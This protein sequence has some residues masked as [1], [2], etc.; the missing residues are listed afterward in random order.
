M[1]VLVTGA[2]GFIG[3]NLCEALQNV[4]DDEGRHDAYRDLLPL[5]IFECH[6]GTPKEDLSLFCEQAD[7]VFDLAGVTR[8]RDSADH[9]RVNCGFLSDTLSLLEN[10]GNRCPVMLAS[11]VW[12]TLLGRYEGSEY[13]MSKLAAER[14]LFEYAKRTGARAL[15]YRF[16]NV[17]GKWCRP[18]YSS[19]VATFCDAIANDRPYEVFDPAA[20][21]ELLYI[22]DLVDEMFFAMLG[23]EHRCNYK[24]LIPVPDS[25]GRYCY[26]PVTDHVALGEIVE[27]LNSFKSNHGNLSA[28]DGRESSFSKKLRITFESYY[29]KGSLACP[30]AL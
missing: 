17:Y 16:P 1:R 2:G 6:S 24:G 18:N 23:E 9:M 13:G 7:F 22:G 21:L 30:A 3:K 14:R 5:T 19:V 26:C 4:R 15:V 28:T 20:E 25:N 12:A 8:P 29:D 27:L 11:S 10:C